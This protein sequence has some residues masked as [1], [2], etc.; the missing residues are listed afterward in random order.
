MSVDIRLLVSSVVLLATHT[1]PSRAVEGRDSIDL[2]FCDH[3]RGAPGGR[4]AI[5][6]RVMSC[7]TQSSHIM[8]II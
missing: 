8:I 7:G 1:C 4:H 3:M 6:I 5:F 2:N